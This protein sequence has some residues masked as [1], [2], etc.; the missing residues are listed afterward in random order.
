M[1]QLPAFLAEVL[2]PAFSY[3]AALLLLFVLLRNIRQSL[4]YRLKRRSVAIDD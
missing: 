4:W 3:E 2:G 1:S